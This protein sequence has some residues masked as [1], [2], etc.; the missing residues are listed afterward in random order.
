[1]NVPQL[2]QGDI[3]QAALRVQVAVVFGHVGFN[4]MRIR[5]ATF[6]AT[7]AKLSHVKDPFTELTGRAVEWCPGRWLWFIAE[8]ENHGM[9]DAQVMRAL[10]TALSWASQKGLTS[11]ATNGIANTDHGHSTADNRRSDEQ[12]AA[13]LTDYAKRAEQNYGLAIELISMNDVFTRARQ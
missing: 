9:T 1:M 11:A 4:E 2:S 10:D 13:L 12:R 7:Q 6:A 3:F 8:E 5:W